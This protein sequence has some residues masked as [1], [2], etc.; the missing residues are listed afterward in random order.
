MPYLDYERTKE[1]ALNYYYKHREEVLKKQNIRMMKRYHSD[2]E[3]KRIYNIRKATG[4]KFPL[5]D[6]VCV[7]CKTS[8][9]L[10]RHHLRYTTKR[11]D[12]I[13]L[14]RTHHNLLHHPVST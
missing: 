6:E 9:N 4:H 11:E 2:P 12:F 7:E 10:Q 8:E 3:F 14:C 13:V 1:G 5:K